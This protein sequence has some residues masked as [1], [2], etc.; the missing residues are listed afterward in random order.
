MLRSSPDYADDQSV[1]AHYRSYGA[2]RLAALR[3]LQRLVQQTITGTVSVGKTVTM[4]V[5]STESQTDASETIAKT[6]D[7]IDRE[8]T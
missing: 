3:L 1:L 6:I 5:P 2:Q 8:A 4:A 7:L